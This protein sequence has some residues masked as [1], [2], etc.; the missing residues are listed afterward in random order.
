MSLAEYKRKRNFRR[1]PEPSGSREKTF[2]H[3]F[4]IQKHA[5]SRLH[6]DFRLE[7]DGVLKSWAIPKGPSLDPHDKVLAVHVEDH[8]LE[9]AAFE[10]IIPEGEYGGGTVMVW[11]R[12]TWEPEEDAEQGFRRGKLK[13]KL[14]GE[15]LKGS[16]ALVQMS[17]K[18]GAGGKNWLLIKHRDRAARPNAKSDFLA[19]HARSVVSGRT[20]KEIAA[21]ADRT[22]TSDNK[23]AKASSKRRAKK[24]VKAGKAKRTKK[25]AKKRG[26]SKSPSRRAPPF[27]ASDVGDLPGAREVRLPHSFKPQLATL[28]DRPPTG[29]Q[30]LHELKFDGYR[31]LTYLRDGSA[32][33]V[34]RN[35]KDWTHRFP[36]LAAALGELPVSS[37]LL[38]GEVVLLDKKGRSDFQELQNFLRRGED[39][40]LVYYVFDAPHLAGYDLTATP[41]IKRKEMLARL[42]LADKASNAGPIRYSDHIQGSG[43]EV[44]AQACRGHQ[45]GIVSKLDDSHYVQFRSQSWIKTKCHQRQELVVGGFT[46][47]KVPAS[48]SA[49]CFWAI[50]VRAS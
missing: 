26:R 27:E 19:R 16:W 4:V 37:T 18:A 36:S 20:M 30:W 42:L 5:A 44:L 15:K 3:S 49:R 34:S 40:A 8:P 38:D 48:G 1:T 41:L 45:E 6:Y 43:E 22:W 33:L 9:Y 7:L 47:R 23:S 46:R 2:S 35:G 50:I 10:G 12:G 29:D 14:H 11:D 21:D 39:S 24:T 13:F 31:I 32:R 25:T 28:H 17:G